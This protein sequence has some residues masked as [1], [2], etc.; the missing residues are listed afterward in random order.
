MATRPCL[1][2]AARKPRNP[3]SSP[4]LLKPAGSKILAV[5]SHLPAWQDRN[6]PTSAL[7]AGRSCRQC[8]PRCPARHEQEPRSRTSG[9]EAVIH[10]IGGPARSH[11]RKAF[12]AS[13]S[14]GPLARILRPVLQRNS[15]GMTS[16][17][18]H[19]Q[20]ASLHWFACQRLQS[21][22]INQPLSPSRRT[23]R[24]NRV[25]RVRDPV[26]GNLVVGG[27]GVTRGPDD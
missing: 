16:N 18:K 13:S 10:L 17:S 27:R 21:P 15:G 5:P 25:R 24:S 20:Q 12:A 9:P 1:I 6:G 19:S 4:T 3:V 2:S 8:P 11:A 7:C 14:T 22:K 23:A 26:M